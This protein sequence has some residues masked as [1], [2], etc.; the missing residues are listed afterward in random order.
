MGNE[1]GKPK[2]QV[3]DEKNNGK[4]DPI[5]LNE[6]LPI[7]AKKAIL[8]EIPD[9]FGPKTDEVKDSAR[10]SILNADDDLKSSRLLYSNGHYANAIYHLQQAVEKLAKGFSGD[11]LPLKLDEIRKTSHNSP[12]IY[13]TL[14]KDPFLND[15]LKQFAEVYPILDIKP[16]K[17]VEDLMKRLKKD[18]FKGELAKLPT[19]FLDKILDICDVFLD[20][21]R[22]VNIQEMFEALYGSKW[23][24][25]AKEIIVN[26]FGEVPGVKEYLD[27]NELKSI[28]DKVSENAEKQIMGN[29]TVF[30]PLYIVSVITYSHE[31][32]ARYSDTNMPVTREEYRKDF[33]IVEV[34]P[35]LAD[36]CERLISKALEVI[37]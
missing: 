16:L 13:L 28:F 37:A 5:H 25:S 12:L 31:A 9:I 17:D 33:G 35:R 20:L 8:N 6:I 3:D 36:I 19:I 15:M 22:K 4:V 32:F 7:F 14:L 11:R 26:A 2:E 21:E 34:Y 30:L 23:S 1:K 27:R 18:D 24:E 29:I 10:K